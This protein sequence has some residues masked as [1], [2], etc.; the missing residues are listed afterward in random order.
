MIVSQKRIEANR[1]N[2][3]KSTGPTSA[4]GKDSSRLNALKHGLTAIVVVPEDAETY[5]KAAAEMFG[6]LKPRNTHQ[7]ELVD[8]IALI[9]L[10]TRRAQRIERKLRDQ[11]SLRAITCWDD[12]RRLEAERVA[13]DLAGRPSEV[14]AELRRTP[15]GCDLMLERWAML[16]NVA[17]QWSADQ[18]RL[19]FDLLGT[20][21]EFRSGR[22]GASIDSDGR[23]VDKVAGELDVARGQ[24]ASLR[25]R[26]ELSAELDAIAR[27]IAE[28]DLSDETTPEIRRIRRYESTLHGR[29]RWCMARLN[30]EIPT[31]RPLGHL[32]PAYHNPQTEAEEGAEA[33][34]EL[35]ERTAKN[36]REYA[37]HD[38]RLRAEAKVREKAEARRQKRAEARAKVK[39]KE[40]AKEAELERLAELDADY[41]QA[42]ALARIAAR[43][44]A[45]DE[46]QARDEA[47]AEMRDEATPEMRNEANI[48]PEADDPSPTNAAKSPSASPRG[49]SRPGRGSSQPPRA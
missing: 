30:D 20:P 19:A 10:R 15:Q 11:A 38:A 49:A 7:A 21:P 6:S 17:G 16:A 18:R 31:H 23:D 8:Q 27:E 36:E 13:R 41:L 39:A 37:E 24:I 33:D 32:A 4:E 40:A 14:V 1:R 22:P 5:Q 46:A 47:T 43:K 3:L 2:A 29:L 44:E 26:R 28:A 9:T 35:R 42:R 34:A 25:E 12:D 48:G 45:F